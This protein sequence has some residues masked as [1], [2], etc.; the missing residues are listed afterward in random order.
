MTGDAVSFIEDGH[1]YFFGTKT[2]PSVTQILVYEG[3]ID[4]RYFTKQGR[5]RGSA[6]HMVVDHHHKS[7]GCMSLSPSIQGYYDA[8]LSFIK[9]SQWYPHTIEKPMACDQFAGTPD[10]IGFMGKHEAVL[11]IK[12]GSI[13]VATGLQL[14]G[15][16]KLYG[17]PL[18]RWALQLKSDGGY[19]LTRYKDPNDMYIFQSAVACW[20]WKKRNNI[21]GGSNNGC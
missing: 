13:S 12:T 11:D 16:E 7:H 20:W 5:N 9:D 3:F 21:G 15:Y 1:L 10:Q 19:K 17:H 8:Y 14:S 18:Q 4:T 2:V 6:V